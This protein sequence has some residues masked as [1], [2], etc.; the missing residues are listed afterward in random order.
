M[1]P[2]TSRETQSRFTGQMRG[3]GD[4]LRPFRE[5]FLH[6][7]GEEGGNKWICH[8]LTRGSTTTLKWKRECANG[9]D[10]RCEANLS[11]ASVRPAVGRSVFM[12]RGA[13]DF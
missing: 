12:I 13:R 9:R 10:E 8:N 1:F 2:G 7:W 3:A 4:A 6:D 5:R 11:T